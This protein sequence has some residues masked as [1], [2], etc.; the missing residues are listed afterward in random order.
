MAITFSRQ[1]T[2]VRASTSQYWENLVRV[3]VLVLDSKTSKLS[4][5]GE[6]EQPDDD[7]SKNL[8]NKHWFY[9]QSNSTPHVSRSAVYFFHVHCTTRTWNF[10]MQRFMED[11]NTMDF[12]FLFFKINTA[13]KNSTAEMFA[14]IWQNERG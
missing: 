9:Q 2:S 3:V 14:D 10:L 13:L 8:K 11:V 12:F 5:T 7:G 6:P 4:I 1:T